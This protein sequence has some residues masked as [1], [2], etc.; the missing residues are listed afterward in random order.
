MRWKQSKICWL[1]FFSL[2]PLTSP[3]SR[4]SWSSVTIRTMLLAF[5]LVSAHLTRQVSSAASSTAAAAEAPLRRL[6]EAPV[7]VFW[8]AIGSTSAPPDTHK[9][10][11]AHSCL[12]ALDP[13]EG[14]A[15]ARCTHTQSL[16]KWSWSY[17]QRGGVSGGSEHRVQIR[18]TQLLYNS[19]IKSAAFLKPQWPTMMIWCE[20]HITS[21]F[22][23]FT[24]IFDLFLSENI[25][26][27]VLVSVWVTMVA[28]WSINI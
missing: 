2:C 28:M 9:H 24:F 1:L 16:R 14:N 23:I 4:T 21:R 26:L 15:V 10:T 5:A 13:G 8:T 22:L 17:D 6:V 18:F 11:H 7:L 25:N 19:F 27:P 12:A 20:V 3:P